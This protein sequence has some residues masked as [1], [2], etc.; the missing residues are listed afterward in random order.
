MTRSAGS[1]PLTVVRLGGIALV[2]ATGCVA[3]CGS[4]RIEP[5]A[6][7]KPTP[8][9]FEVVPHS[10]SL[11]SGGTAR[12]AALLNATIVTSAE[13][14]ASAG[15][16]TSDGRYV[17]PNEL[18]SYL[19]QAR[20]GGHTGS[21]AANV[22][23]SGSPAA[24]YAAAAAAC[25]DLPLRATGVIRY[26]CDCQNAGLAGG[27]ESGCVPGADANAGT[28]PSAPKRTWPQIVAAFNAL[29]AGDT[30]AL[31]KGGAWATSGTSAFAN[32]R[33]RAPVDLMAAANTTT[34]DL[35]E[36]A[37]GWGGTAKPIV[38]STSGDLIQ[39]ASGA[40]QG[41]RILN[42]ELRGNGTGPGGTSAGQRAI[43]TQGAVSDFL[44]CNNTI[45]GWA[46]GFHLIITPPPGASRFTVTGNR[47]LNSVNDGWL[48]G[49]A[50]SAIDANFWDNNGSSTPTTH[51]VYLQGTAMTNFSF[52]NNEIRHSRTSCGGTQLVIHDQFDGLNIEN[53]VVDGGG[54]PTG[55]C[56]G[57]AIDNGGYPT[58][59]YYRHLTIRRNLITNSG[60][61]PIF[62]S[63]APGAVIENNVIV[64]RL[65]SVGI[66]IPGGAARTSMGEPITTGAAIRN[67]TIYFGST[68]ATSTGI[69]IGTEGTN[70][71]VANNA[72]L[73]D[74]ASGGTC[75]NLSLPAASYD[76][77]DHNLC[78][79]FR[80]WEAARGS[81]AAWRTYSGGRFDAASLAIAPLFA[82]A[83]LDLSPGPGS[84]LTGAGVAAY[85]PPS[86]FALKTRPTPPSIGALEP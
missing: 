42:L 17:A 26:F 81:L 78:F 15:T 57:I 28:S 41:V 31:C 5:A 3:G 29:N 7:A 22:V 30:V 86:D 13:W 75:Y 72:I 55:Q 2:F 37:P 70:Y 53:N 40:P 49:A 32:A 20:Y 48:G 68:A 74:G 77:V 64:A 8:T 25:A 23:S 38:S 19:I 14:S 10:V 6:Q 39:F 35:R 52:V 63:E 56:W 21:A 66:T 12:F 54:S 62:A 45:D 18:G 11:L 51:A 58:A 84:P 80:S 27:A 46:F 82:N 50:N 16:I 59:G 73:F 83:P 67:N 47:I 76:Y 69:A 4:A 61:A 71:V 24:L 33:C 65:S 79:G 36:Y 85:A 43:S 44:V 9:Q 34:C 60:Y 1:L